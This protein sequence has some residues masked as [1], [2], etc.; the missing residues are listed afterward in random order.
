[1]VFHDVNIL[2]GNNKYINYIVYYSQPYGYPYFTLQKLKNTLLQYIHPNNLSN[3]SLAIEV[4][5]STVQ[6][7]PLN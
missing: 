4:H 3:V 2:M 1:M 6:S 7:K 5:L